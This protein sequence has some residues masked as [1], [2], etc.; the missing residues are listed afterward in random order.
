MISYQES[1][2]SFVTTLYKL[3]GAPFSLL[4]KYAYPVLVEP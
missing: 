2:N 4:N 3:L 1:Y